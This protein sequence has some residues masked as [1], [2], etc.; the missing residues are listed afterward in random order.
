MKKV[1]LVLLILSMFFVFA[2]CN[3]N[4]TDE[5][6][7]DEQATDTDQTEQPA[8]VNR[9][10]WPT[11]L[12]VG[13]GSTGGMLYVLANGFANL[14]TEYLE[15]N[16]AVQE[17]G[18]A[19]DNIMLIQL[20]EAELGLASS[21][22]MVE[23]W[24]GE[25]VWN[26]DGTEY[27]NIRTLVPTHPSYTYL[28]YLENNPI[29]GWEDI[30]NKKIGFGPTTGTPATQ[31]PKI[32]EL[33]GFQ[34]KEVVYGSFGDMQSQLADGLIDGIIYI[35]T[36]P[37][38]GQVELESTYDAGYIAPPAELQEELVKAYPEY[39]PGVLPAGSYKGLPE[40][41][42]TV[43]QWFYCVGSKDL[44]DDFV[45]ELVKTYFEQTEYLDSVLN[46]WSANM[47]AEDVLSSPIPL[48]P[49]AI[50]YY[51]EIGLEIPDTLRP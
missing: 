44:P 6:P 13:G 20:G 50:R 39:S 29:N 47:S 18:A 8:E 1:F 28:T 16:T 7:P 2:A 42:N 25:G 5:A 9:D 12:R 37:Y 14:V 45:Y 34:P 31:W 36:Y 32:F 26:T 15:V 35:A 17:T 46:S 22:T 33:A 49:G 30:A 48:H 41:L 11:M 38:A 3:S 51:E 19:A 4:T 21:G 23:A 10:N 43:L 40:D 24:N 27:Q